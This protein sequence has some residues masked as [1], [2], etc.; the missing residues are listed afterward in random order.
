MNE[1]KAKL[2]LFPTKEGQV[3]KGE[4]PDST[5]AKLKNVEQN[6]RPSFFGLPPVVKTSPPEAITKEMLAAK[7]YQKLRAERINKR[8]EGKR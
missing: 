5:A 3:K 1:Y 4:I 7:V 8:Y 2:I 6:E